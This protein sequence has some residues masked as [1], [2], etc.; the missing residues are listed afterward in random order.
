MK[1]YGLKKFANLKNS[2]ALNVNKSL[3]KN[4]STPLNVSKSFRR[5]PFNSHKWFS[6][7]LLF[8]LRACEWLLSKILF[9]LR[10]TECALQLKYQHQIVGD[11]V[12]QDLLSGLHQSGQ[13]SLLKVS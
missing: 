10:A 1:K 3:D 11:W 7:E 13:G 6:S 9:T 2:N 4:Y 5:E 12:W 8:T